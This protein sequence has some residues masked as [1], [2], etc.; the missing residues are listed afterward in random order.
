[1]FPSICPGSLDRLLTIQ[2]PMTVIIAYHTGRIGDNQRFGS[3]IQ[4][5]KA[6]DNTSV[7][8]INKR[9]INIQIN[10]VFTLCANAVS[11][12]LFGL[13]ARRPTPYSWLW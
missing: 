6:D 12:F 10:G 13:I 1:M 2:H 5:V 8:G 4:I 3:V 7:I 9:F 11:A